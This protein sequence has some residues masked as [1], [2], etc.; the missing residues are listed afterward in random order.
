MTKTILEIMNIPAPSGG[1]KSMAD[2]IEQAL[3]GKAEI[4]RDVLGNIVARKKGKSKKKLMI[5]C[6]MDEPGII[7]SE[8]GEFS[9]ITK[10]GKYPTELLCGSTVI[11]GDIFG[12]AHA[13]KSEKPEAG[14]IFIETAEEVPVG[15]LGAVAQNTR[16]IGERICG[17]WAGGKSALAAALFAAETD[18]APVYD[19]YFVFEAQGLAGG[20]GALAAAYN[21]KPDY[22]ISV[23]T[24]AAN[25]FPGGKGDIESGGGAVL[26]LADSGIICDKRII[27]HIRN[28]K[29]GICTLP[30]S[31][32]SFDDGVA[33]TA[34]GGAIS[35]GIVLPVRHAGSA[36]EAVSLYDI[37]D[38][39]DLIIAC[40]GSEIEE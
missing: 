28:K 39:T 2:Y 24:C 26:K 34:A 6:R 18:F 10:T 13:E 38:V 29:E 9:R 4:S 21:I 27:S 1:E 7:V 12:V 19:T 36:C 32:E 31:E 23:G 3:A 35:G 5:L 8:S 11:M 14:D 15:T 33:H 22:C 40:C 30:V 17:V 20:R 25:D 16:L 37:N